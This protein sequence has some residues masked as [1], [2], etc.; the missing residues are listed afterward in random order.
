MSIPLRS[1]VEALSLQPFTEL[2]VW[3]RSHA[4]V[5]DV[6]ALSRAFPAEERF[7]LVS[8]LRRAAM[9]VPRNIA[10]GSRRNDPLDFAKLLNIAEGSLGE[11]E[12][13]LMLCRD[14]GHAQPESIRRLMEEANEIARMLHA[15]R[16]SVEATR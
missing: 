13:L 4:F 9:S 3:Q 5:L 6:Y 15:F 8:Q 12:Y 7:G 2:R 14:L 16:R 1:D 11:V 10:E